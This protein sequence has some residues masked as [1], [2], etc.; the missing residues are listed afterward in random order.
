MCMERNVCEHTANGIIESQPRYY[1]PSARVP[2][3][4]TRAANAALSKVLVHAAERAATC[5]MTAGCKCMCMERNVCAHTANGT[6]Q[7]QPRYY[8]P[9]AEMFLLSELCSVHCGG[10]RAASAALS[11]VVLHVAESTNAQC[12][13]T[14]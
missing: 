11:Q 13:V 10:T 3:G 4:G 8:K 5:R 2:R 6:I 7:S 12:V 9:S 1:K 14:K